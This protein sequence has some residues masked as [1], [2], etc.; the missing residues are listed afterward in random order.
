MNS[1]AEEK[2]QAS[3]RC[4]ARGGTFLEIGKFDLMNENRLDLELFKR[5][6]R[7]YS[8]HLDRIFRADAN[9]KQRVIKLL[10]DAIEAGAVK[11]L[12]RLVFAVDRVEEAFRFMASGG[13][14]GKVLIKVKEERP[15]A[16]ARFYCDG[17]GCVVIAGGL[18]GFG[19]ELVDWLVRRGARK[20]VLNSRNGIKSGYQA[21]RIKY[22][23]ILTSSKTTTKKKPIFRSW[24]NEGVQIK[25]SKQDITTRTGCKNLLQ[26]ASVLGPIN[27]IFNLAVILADALFENQTEDNFKKSLAPKAFATQHLDELTRTM[28]PHLRDFVVFSS[29][30]CGRGNAGQTN[31]GTANSI[32]ERICEQRRNHGL[33]GLAIQWGAVGD[34]NQQLR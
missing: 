31:Y 32:M 27:S 18:G 13:H 30:S 34:V 11:P 14:I 6:I 9:V 23:K 16:H 33:P 26:E 4:L 22:Y 25:I 10:I 1:L 21:L 2:L 20:I 19:L 5:E 3:L 15:N 7:F 12:P 28:C 17:D 8:V 24:I 29:V